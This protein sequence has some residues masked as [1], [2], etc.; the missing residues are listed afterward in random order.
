MTYAQLIKYFGTQIEAA[1]A[2]GV[3]QTTVS[4]WRKSFPQWRQEW[5]RLKLNGKRK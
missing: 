1:R 3:P 2:L 5:V 4:A